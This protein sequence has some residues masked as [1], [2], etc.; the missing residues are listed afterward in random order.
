V[1]GFVGWCVRVLAFCMYIDMCVRMHKWH[2]SS[3]YVY[4]SVYSYM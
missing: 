4:V 2:V 1:S 3:G